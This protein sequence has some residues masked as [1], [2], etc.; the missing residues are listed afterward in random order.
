MTNLTKGEVSL[1]VGS[2]RLTLKYDINALCELEDALDK[3]IPELAILFSDV[4]KIRLKDLRVVFWA[5]LIHSRPE[6]TIKEAGELISSAG[7]MMP[8]MDAVGR[9][10]SETFPSGSEGSSDKKARPH[11]G[12]VSKKHGSRGA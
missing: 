4:K 1:E 12:Q 7:G 2:E 9:A 3:G 8:V 5:G 6:L 10:L 11:S